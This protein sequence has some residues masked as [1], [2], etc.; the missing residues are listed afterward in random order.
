MAKKAEFTNFTFR[1]EDGLRKRAAELAEEK[2]WSLGSWVARLVAREVAS[3][4][5]E[6]PRPSTRPRKGSA[7][8]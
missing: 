5:S 2:G 1:F 4:D 7:P 3:L 6:H 8:S